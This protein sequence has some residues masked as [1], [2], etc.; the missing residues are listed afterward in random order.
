MHNEK[1]TTDLMI[2]NNQEF[3]VEAREQN[4][5]IE[6]KIDGVARSLGLTTV[7]K[8]GNDCVRWNRLNEYLSEFGLS[9]KVTTGDFLAEQ[10]VYLL[11]MKANS[12]IA[13]AFQKWLAFDV[14]PNIRKHGAYI[15]EHADEEYVKN[16]LRFSKRRTI[17]TFGSANVSELKKLYKE[18]RE[19]VDD[20]YKYKTDERVSRYKSVEKGLEIAH[21]IAA[22][23]VGN[24]G[25][26]YNIR[27]LMGQVLADRTTLEKRISGGE[28]SAKTK[29]ICDLETKLENSLPLPKAEDF[30]VLNVHGISNNN[31]YEFCDGGTFKSESYQIWLRKFPRYQV[32]P[33]EHWNVDWNKPIEMF[34]RYVVKSEFGGHSFDSHNFN[35]ATI[36]MIIN[37]LYDEDDRIATE[38]HSKEIGTCNTFQEGKIL[39][40]IR[41]V[42]S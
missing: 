19:Y 24:I 10:Y 42:L 27:R 15:S 14:L 4:G 30:I 20:E 22:Q 37:K 1:A 32:A 17:K 35:K 28:K 2:F 40:Y 25:D 39:Y 8:S 18:F 7:A 31:L 29:K 12:K 21:N 33:K 26:C 23:D 41:N 9:Q 6:F 38:I 5:N 11:G 34:I 36:D 16:E 3:S 13:I